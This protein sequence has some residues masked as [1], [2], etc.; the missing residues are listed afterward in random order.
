MKCF[1]PSEWLPWHY[2]D[3]NWMHGMRN[4]SVNTNAETQWAIEIMK[5]CYYSF[6][7]VGSC[8]P[9][10]WLW[11]HK[12][13]T[14]YSIISS[15]RNSECRAVR[16]FNVRFRQSDS[17]AHLSLSFVRIHLYIFGWLVNCSGCES[18]NVVDY[19]YHCSESDWRRMHRQN[20]AW[21]FV[22]DR[23]EAATF[24]A[25]N[26]NEMKIPNLFGSKSDAK[27]DANLFRFSWS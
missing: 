20:S 10:N 14:R 19:I 9:R 8:G 1:L 12:L 23:N 6:H 4:W 15:S 21:T 3:E 11:V 5:L 16:Q 13:R 2:R 17:E 22:N 18:K 25:N 24:R 26:K 27:T 7:F